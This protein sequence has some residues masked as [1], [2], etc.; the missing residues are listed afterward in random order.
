[1]CLLGLGPSRSNCSDDVH[2][3][4]GSRGSKDRILSPDIE[5]CRLEAHFASA[6]L[7]SG[8]NSIV[9]PAEVL[10][11]LHAQNL[12]GV[13]GVLRGEQLGNIG[14]PLPE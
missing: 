1:M 2:P 5:I 6:F 12:E 7:V 10:Q 8:L 3:L 14:D 4:R 9:S 11:V 13:P